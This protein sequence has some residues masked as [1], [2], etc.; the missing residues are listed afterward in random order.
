MCFESLKERNALRHAK[1]NN[2]VSEQV[3]TNQAV[4]LKNCT[5]CVAKTKAPLF[6]HMYNVCF[7]MMQLKYKKETESYF[8]SKVIDL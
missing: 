1:T 8:V 7:L 4:Q 3:I 6:S 5:I 2:V